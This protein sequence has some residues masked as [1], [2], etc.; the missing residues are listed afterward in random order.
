MRNSKVHKKLFLAMARTAPTFI[1]T[2][3]IP[4]SRTLAFVPII[5]ES[6][7]AAV[8]LVPFVRDF[9]GLG[10]ARPLKSSLAAEMTLGNV[11]NANLQ[12]RLGGSG[13]N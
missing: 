12:V 10:N 7:R 5:D 4:D 3:Q 11:V 2:W 6:Q 8:T 9:K 1:T 13:L